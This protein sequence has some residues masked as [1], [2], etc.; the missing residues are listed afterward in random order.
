M[1]VSNTRIDFLR[2]LSARLERLSV[3]SIWAR[4]A[5]GL[6]RSLFKALEAAEAGHELPPEQV[7]ALLE[8]SFDI[9]RKAAQEI[10]A[11][12]ELSDPRSERKQP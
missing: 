12:G 2:L 3:D 7:D 9:L 10:P 4:R 8:R 11:S 1:T 6:R 5:S